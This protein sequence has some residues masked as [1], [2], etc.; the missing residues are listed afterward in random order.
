MI[1]PRAAFKESYRMK[2]LRILVAVLVLLVLVILIVPAFVDPSFRIEKSI[3][4]QAPASNVYG[5]IADLRA[6]ESWNYWST[7]DDTMRFQY[8]AVSRG[9]GAS[10]RWAGA[11]GAGTTTILATQVDESVDI[12]LDFGKRGKGK[13]QW[14][15]RQ[16][17]GQTELTWTFSGNA[18]GYMG[19]W[20]NVV[21]GRMMATPMDESL[22]KIKELAEA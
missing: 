21:I 22:A 5:L 9:P 4:V 2:I 20:F 13:A 1:V 11:D 12:A 3:T 8:G 10:Y 6:W 19:R 7:N 17:N 16:A 18:K 14:T 15:L